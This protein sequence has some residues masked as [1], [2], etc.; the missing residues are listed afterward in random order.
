MDGGKPANL[1]TY[2]RTVAGKRRKR[3]PPHALSPEEIPI[4][5]IGIREAD[6]C[7]GFTAAFSEVAPRGELG[8]RWYLLG[9]FRP[10]FGIWSG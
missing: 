7:L 1:Q 10:R 9:V 3:Y 4:G 6:A 2:V 8:L 5:S